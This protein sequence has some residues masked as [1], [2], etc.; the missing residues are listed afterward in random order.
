MA[1]TV[2]KNSEVEEVAEV[3]E[4]VAEVAEGVAAVGKEGRVEDAVALGPRWA[5]E[6]KDGTPSKSRNR[7]I[8]S[9]GGHLRCSRWVESSRSSSD[10]GCMF[11]L[12]L[13]M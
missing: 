11:V 1:A 13:H 7:K 8:G 9:Q 2:V 4:G 10:P 12:D 6:A 3:A 5:K